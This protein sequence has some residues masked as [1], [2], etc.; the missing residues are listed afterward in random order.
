MW[1]I[2]KL[3]TT[4]SFYTFSSVHGPRLIVLTLLNK[5]KVHVNEQNYSMALGHVV[6]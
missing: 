3:C 5:A 6:A 2:I 4:A 1:L